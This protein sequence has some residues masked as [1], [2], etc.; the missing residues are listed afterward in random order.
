MDH[1]W[2][3]AALASGDPIFGLVTTTLCHERWGSRIAFAQAKATPRVDVAE[4]PKVEME[5]EKPECRF[6]VFCPHFLWHPHS[7]CLQL[8][9]RL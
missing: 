9:A 1:G 8:H 5:L 4:T 3:V 2:M 7:L 6:P